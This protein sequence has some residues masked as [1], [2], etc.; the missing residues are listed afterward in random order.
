MRPPSATNSDPVEYELSSEA[1]KEREFRDLFRAIPNG[2]RVQ[3]A[4]YGHSGPRGS[5][6]G[7]MSSPPP[8]EV[9]I[10]PGWIELTRIPAVPQFH[11]SRFGHAAHGPL[12]RD[13]GHQ[14]IHPHHPI[15]GRN[16][17]NRSSTGRS[18]GCDCRAHAEK[19]SGL[20][21]FGDAAIAIES[22]LGKRSRFGDPRVIDQDVK[23]SE[24]FG[25]RRNRLLPVILIGDVQVLIKRAA[26]RWLARRLCLHHQ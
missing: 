21:H 10:K 12:A 7:S 25:G 11:G 19:N 14:I 3:D 22:H 8:I 24:C 9:K 23:F 6:A 1:R 18:H 5:C 2:P 15:D 13:V 17:D 16:V 26:P 20:I 4:R